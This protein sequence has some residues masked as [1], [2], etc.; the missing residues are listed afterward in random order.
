MTTP[1]IIIRHV[2][3]IA[4]RLWAIVVKRFKRH[5]SI[6][7]NFSGHLTFV[8]SWLLSGKLQ[9]T[10]PQLRTT[11]LLPGPPNYDKLNWPNAFH[12]NSEKLHEFARFN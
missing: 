4:H 5:L 6:N 9:P 11:F 10:A 3:I 8:L 2:E 1:P 7:G 12:W